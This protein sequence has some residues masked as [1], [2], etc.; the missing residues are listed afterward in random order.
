MAI[1]YA[2]TKGFADKVPVTKM[3]SF[4]SDYLQEPTEMTDELREMAQHPSF[5]QMLKYTFAGTR[6]TVKK[7]TEDFLERTGVNELIVV[8]NMY[9][10]VDRV[11]SYRIF[12]DIMHEIN[13]KKDLVSNH[14][15]FNGQD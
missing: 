6:E 11:E 12:S 1:I 10:H 14:L 2:S 9:N 4:E 15:A 7:S 8:S 3:K 5:Q 13:S